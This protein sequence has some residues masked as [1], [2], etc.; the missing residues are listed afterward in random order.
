MKITPSVCPEC[1]LD[2]YGTCDQ[3]ASTVLLDQQEDGT[4]E[5][6]GESEMHWDTSTTETNDNGQC[7]VCCE[8]GHEW[9]A[10]IED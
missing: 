6:S 9:W 3:V 4:F 8:N 7:R 10:N 2:V 1:G 5:Y